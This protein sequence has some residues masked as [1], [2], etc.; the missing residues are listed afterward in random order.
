MI[1][2]PHDGAHRDKRFSR[3]RRPVAP[4]LSWPW[5]TSSSL[6]QALL[7]YKFGAWFVN[8]GEIWPSQSG[9]DGAGLSQPEGREVECGGGRQIESRAYQYQF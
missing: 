1:T 3:L 9:K 4:S 8:L 5:C 6:W 2:Y 7:A